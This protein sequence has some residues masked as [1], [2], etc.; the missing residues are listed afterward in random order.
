MLAAA[1]MHLEAVHENH[2]DPMLT[3]VEEI[4]AESIAKSRR[5]SHD[6]SPAVLYQ[7]GLFAALQW[8]TGQMKEQFE[9]HV[10]LVTHA[11][12]QLECAPLNSFL[13]RAVQE[14]L[15]NTVKHAGVR[16]ARVAV[17][18][19]ANTLT[20]TVSDRGRGFDPNGINACGEKAGFGLLSIR[21][22]ASYIGGRLIIESSPGK[23]SRFTL[24]VPVVLSATEASSER[25]PAGAQPYPS[26]QLPEAVTG[27]ENLRVLLV[28]DH[29]AMRQG[30][31]QLI[32]PQPGIRVVGEAA[33]G[34]EALAKARDLSPDVIIM[35]VSMPEMDGIEAT[36]R[37]RSEMPHVRVIG[38]SMH[39]D[40]HITRTMQE[41]GAET[42]ISKTAS[43]AELFR[44]IYG[45]QP[46]E[47]QPLIRMAPKP[48]GRK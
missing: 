11:E 1:K 46:V 41:A 23:G 15:F 30:L 45:M 3:R 39:E 36:R 7:A 44:A 21:E 24:T 27:A 34:R 20:I 48:I 25:Q 42:L 12:Q 28:D 10:E 2:P 31:I 33:N 37:I 29:T 8:L 47:D 40:D 16:N 35:D 32:D 18:G 14:L 5:L 19:N 4:L 38:L 43:S 22:R 26:G 17:S 13:F 6:L 9:L